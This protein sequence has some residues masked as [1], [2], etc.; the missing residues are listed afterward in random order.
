MPEEHLSVKLAESLDQKAVQTEQNLV[1]E[2][3]ENRGILPSSLRNILVITGVLL[4]ITGTIYFVIRKIPKTETPEPIAIPIAQEE[5][6][7]IPAAI[8]EGRIGKVLGADSGPSPARA[9]AIMDNT[10]VAYKRAMGVIP[11]PYLR[12]ENSGDAHVVATRT[13]IASTT[14]YTISA[15]LPGTDDDQAYTV[16]L[17]SEGSS[18]YKLGI[19]THESPLTYSLS[20][21]EPG[22]NTN[23]FVFIT[24][25]DPKA[26]E[27]EVTLLSGIFQTL[28]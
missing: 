26:P 20:I 2:Q 4:L 16:Y 15:F 28:Q 1:D 21:T 3:E 6:P 23:E 14:S 7:D 24:G 13:F 9:Q 17:G 5:I 27:N 10:L 11:H 12:A 22:Y 18:A 8:R 25:P 19:M